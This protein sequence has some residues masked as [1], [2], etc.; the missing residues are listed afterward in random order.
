M[1]K[2]VLFLDFDR[3]LFDTAQFYEWLGKDAESILLEGKRDE[4]DFASML[5]PDTLLFLKSARRSHAL[6]LLT[7]T[8]N[9]LVQKRKVY[10][11][12]IVTFLDDI[13]IVDGV[14]GDYSGKGPA[15]MTYLSRAETAPSGHVFVDDLPESVSEVKTFN[16]K[17][18]CVWINRARG[19]NKILPANSPAP[20]NTITALPEL[21]TL[22]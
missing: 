14:K 10:G 22:L 11:S 12:G 18:R 9:Q 2:P 3:T 20:D 8:A 13:V 17:V 5:Y 16:P 21:L 15:V 4:P 1:R 19:E 6:V 7:S